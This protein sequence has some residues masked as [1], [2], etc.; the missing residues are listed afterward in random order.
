MSE[1][2]LQ[3]YKDS[4]FTDEEIN[5][6]VEEGWI[7]TEE[8][9]EQK[10]SVR[11]EDQDQT[12]D[13]EEVEEVEEEQKE[14][15][16]AE[17]VEEEDVK[18]EEILDYKKGSSKDPEAAKIREK[19]NN[20]EDLSR[21]EHTYAMNHFSKHELGAIRRAHSE[22]L[23]R[24]E[25]ENRLERRDKDYESLKKEFE[26]IR[27]QQLKNVSAQ[28]QQIDP[29][30][31]LTRA[32]W[33]RIQNIERQKEILKRPIP[34]STNQS[35]AVESALNRF[36]E[37]QSFTDPEFLQKVDMFTQVAKSNPKIMQSFM[38]R[39]S[40]YAQGDPFSGNEMK[41]IIDMAV[42]PHMTTAKPSIDSR[43][44]QDKIR[45]IESRASRP[46]SSAM[47]NGS[48]DISESLD[49]DLDL[50]SLAEKPVDYIDRLPKDKLKQIMYG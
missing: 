26:E 44:Q 21:D 13:E 28:D 38:N 17:P 20:G 41:Q 29:D 16:E 25:L 50:Q 49:Q 11:L 12:Q 47:V 9:Q 39:A 31:P 1:M 5:Q 48:K 30:E 18:E 7:S 36:Q 33:E 24:R 3:E 42:A 8:E 27:Q 34:E 46:R 14:E 35:F 23:R 22:R 45:K 43:K 19:V 2:T 32:E 4:G 40:L 10:P 6:A 15:I 37:E